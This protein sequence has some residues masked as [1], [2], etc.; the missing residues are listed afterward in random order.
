MPFEVVSGL[1]QRMGVLDGSPCVPSGRSG[2]GV[3]CPIV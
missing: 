1:G 2:F 3:F